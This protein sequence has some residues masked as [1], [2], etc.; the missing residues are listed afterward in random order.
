MD[1]FTKTGPALDALWPLEVVRQLI[2][3][4]ES[5]LP[6]KNSSLQFDSFFQMP[7]PKLFSS[8]WEIV[9]IPPGQ[10]SNARLLINPTK[11]SFDNSCLTLF[12]NVAWLSMS[13]KWDFSFLWVLAMTLQ[14]FRY[15][16][17]TSRHHHKW[18]GQ[19]YF[20]HPRSCVTGDFG[21]HETIM[22]IFSRRSFY[23]P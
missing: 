21:I 7:V 6:L 20:C 23:S 2:D 22:L 3:V 8:R 13:T 16:E 9:N 15:F 4:V 10:K 19:S 14:G 1:V 17:T 18:I 5:H 11:N 12:D